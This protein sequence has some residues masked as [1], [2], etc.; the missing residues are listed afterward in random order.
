M[1]RPKQTTHRLQVMLDPPLH[2]MLQAEA[3][4]SERTASDVARDILRKGL[5]AHC[6]RCGGGGFEE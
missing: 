4:A 5:K 3:E 2:E 1:P 6:G